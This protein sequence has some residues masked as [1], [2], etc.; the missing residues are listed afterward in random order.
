MIRESDVW[1][2]PERRAATLAL[3]SRLSTPERLI[4]KGLIARSLRLNP[5]ADEEIV[6]Y[7]PWGT[8]QLAC[9]RAIMLGGFVVVFIMMFLVVIGSPLAP[10][11]FGVAF[12]LFAAS[13]VRN[14][15]AGK[16]GRRWRAE[17]EGD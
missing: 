5:R 13:Q 14:F 16:E 11:S 2:D 6:K 3:I 10:G 1:L 4:C 9:V 17:H 12:L 8:V 7:G 15:L